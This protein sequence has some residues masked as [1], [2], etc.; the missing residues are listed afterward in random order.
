MHANRQRG[1][2]HS[3]GSWQGCKGW[4]RWEKGKFSFAFWH[5]APMPTSVAT[6]YQKLR[7]SSLL[8][9]NFMKASAILIPTLSHQPGIKG[10][11][12]LCSVLAGL[13]GGQPTLEGCSFS[14]PLFP[15][16]SLAIPPA[17][18]LQARGSEGRRGNAGGLS[19]GKALPQELQRHPYFSCRQ[20]FSQLDSKERYLYRH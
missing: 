5:P 2:Q 1:V 6:C 7:R 11:H 3:Q 16:G 8:K 20:I 12:T 15:F 14:L 4:G 19:L 9:S 17:G 13:R 10:V 18:H